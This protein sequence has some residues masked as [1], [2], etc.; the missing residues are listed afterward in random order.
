MR[1]TCLF[2]SFSRRLSYHEDYYTAL[3]RGA[4][5]AWEEAERESG[6]QLVFKTGGLNLAKKG[7]IS[8]KVLKQYAET[9]E[10]QGV[11]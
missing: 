7:T 4:Y 3:A 8:E 11:P 9:L 1:L 10:K 5:E 2:C 6:E